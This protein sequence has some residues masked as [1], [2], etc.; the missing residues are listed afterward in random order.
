MAETQKALPRASLKPMEQASNG[1]VVDL[2]AGTPKERAL[3]PDFWSHVGAFLSRG[4]IIRCVDES[5]GLFLEL[6]VREGKEASRSGF[7]S[8]SLLR[9]VDLAPIT[10]HEDGL[11]TGHTA[12]WMGEAQKW[13]ALRGSQIL[14]SG[15][16]NKGAVMEYFG[17]LRRAGAV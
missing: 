12:Q 9:T 3:E 11:P 15:F 1:W 6:L 5:T 16:S 10:P 14:K 8:V 17:N 7:V 4:D 2:P 13:A